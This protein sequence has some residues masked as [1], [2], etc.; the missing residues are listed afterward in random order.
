V[1]E[2]RLEDLQKRFGDFVAVQGSTFTI[3]DG[4]FFV[5]LGPS[6]CGKTTTLR[7]IAGLEW[8]SGGR[9][10]LDGED[11][12]ARGA[13]QR[14]IG[15]V[16]QLFALYPHMNV[17]QNIGFPLRCQGVAR[18]EIERR[19][20]EVATLLGIEDLLDRR[21][22]GLSGGDSQR[23]AL[24]R[25]IVRRAKAFMMDEP[26]GALDTELRER[27]CG[28]LRRL[29]DRI[30]ATTV[31]VTHDQ[32]EAMAMA[33]RIAVMNHGLVDQIGSPLEVYEQPATLHVAGFVGSP[34]MNLLPVCAALR[35][36]Q[37]EIDLGGVAV[38]IPA[39][40]QAQT[41]RALVIGVRPEHVQ[42]VGE[43]GLRGE[44]FGSEYLGTV[45][46]VTVTTSWGQVKV[47]APS[48]LPI[49]PNEPV[50]LV[51]RR[52]RMHLFDSATGLAVG[53]APNEAGSQEGLARDQRQTHRR[54]A[55]V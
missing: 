32:V 9:I 22:A 16:F 5:L 34:A 15:F 13:N 23:V 52:D 38:P 6:G 17:R 12:T 29:H 14:D 21:V 49:L 54:V 45:Q 28:E 46:I 7:M 47:R 8:P 40:D 43:G 19:V 27:M 37:E 31:Y 11:V 25:A 55:N 26:L 30:A 18:R 50:G 36:G 41:E 4:E 53:R 3:R 24:G 35:A 33:D 20:N 48:S 42:L 39:P 51:F 10:Y 2:N 1:S 44:V